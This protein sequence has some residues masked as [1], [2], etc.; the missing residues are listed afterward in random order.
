MALEGWLNGCIIF[1]IDD[2]G[3]NLRRMDGWPLSGQMDGWLDGTGR[4]MFEVPNIC[5]SHWSADV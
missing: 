1:K 4:Q 2:G 5:R 3:W